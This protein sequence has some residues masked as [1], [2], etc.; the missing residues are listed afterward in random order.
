MAKAMVKFLEIG[1]QP[2]ETPE[3]DGSGAFVIRVYNPE[4]GEPSHTYVEEN[5]V[6]V[7]RFIKLCVESFRESNEKLLYERSA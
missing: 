4:T 5:E 2:E 7:S 3:Y 1:Y 6:R